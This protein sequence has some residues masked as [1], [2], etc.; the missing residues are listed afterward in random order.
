MKLFPRKVD[1]TWARNCIVGLSGS[2]KGLL[3]VRAVTMVVCPCSL[4]CWASAGMGRVGREFNWS[5][6]LPD[7]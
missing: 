6:S 4:F 7:E 3:Q 1:S 2:T 5:C